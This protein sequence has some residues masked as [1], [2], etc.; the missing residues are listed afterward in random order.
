MAHSL[1]AQS[2]DGGQNIEDEDGKEYE[3]AAMVNTNITCARRRFTYQ[4]IIAKA[5]SAPAVPLGL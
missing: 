4:S 2:T 1:A 3:P 5:R